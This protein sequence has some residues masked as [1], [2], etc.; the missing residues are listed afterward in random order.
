MNN[1]ELE[2]ARIDTA[3]EEFDD[4]EK[5]LDAHISDEVL[6]YFEEKELRCGFV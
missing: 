6:F 2:G 1:D 5:Y 3:L 4:Y